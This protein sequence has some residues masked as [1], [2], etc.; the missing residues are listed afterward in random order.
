[1]KFHENIIIKTLEKYIFDTKNYTQTVF[2][3][4]SRED[5]VGI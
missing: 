1:M 4:C 2:A 5:Y 3:K